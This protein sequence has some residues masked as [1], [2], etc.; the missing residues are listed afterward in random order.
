MKKN[1][2][3]IQSWQIFSSM[4]LDLS[5]TGKTWLSGHTSF[6]S[7]SVESTWLWLSSILVGLEAGNPQNQSLLGT[8]LRCFRTFLRFYQELPDRFWRYY[9]RCTRH[10]KGY[11][12]NT[13]LHTC[14]NV[15]KFVPLEIG[16]KAFDFLNVW[17]VEISLETL[18]TCLISHSLKRERNNNS[19][20][21]KVW[22]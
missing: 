6:W 2:G 5:K 17:K 12:E 21:G 16:W 1:T 7:P 8:F 14:G 19:E 13:Y 3:A 11:S 9:Y 18:S 4:A 10:C 22:T 20:F 15:W